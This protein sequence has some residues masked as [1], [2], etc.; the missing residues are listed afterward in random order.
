[1]LLFLWFSKGISTLLFHN[2]SALNES[3]FYLGCFDNIDCPLRSITN[4]SDCSFNTT[5]LECDNVGD[6][7]F[8]ALA[9]CNLTGSLEGVPS[10]TKL[11]F[12]D[13]SANLIVGTIPQTIIDMTALS[14]L[15]LAANF[16]DGTI[17]LSLSDL[18]ALAVVFLHGNQLIGNIPNFTSIS[19][20]LCVMQEKMRPGNCLN[21]SSF[22]CQLNGGPCQCDV[23]GSICPTSSTSATSTTAT[24]LKTSTVLSPP[25]T[26]F[27]SFDTSTITSL[28]V[29]STIPS[30]LPTSLQ[31]RMS[32]LMTSSTPLIIIIV[33]LS[34]A[35]IVSIG[36]IV[37]QNVNQRRL[38][39]RK[40]QQESERDQPAAGIRAVSNPDAIYDKV[41]P[42]PDQYGPIIIAETVDNE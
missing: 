5:V 19:D 23:D 14:Y 24:T 31:I 42:L 32:P 36:V 40:Q 15:N 9:E 13:L 25:S 21:L 6:V 39:Q 29:A 37:F 18:P 30:L 11:E 16:I 26:I 27:T 7:T 20:D 38:E 28:L 3:L 4:G 12:L 22:A 8:L 35:L 34:L 1:M 10:L 2:Y 17:P 41:L 33:I